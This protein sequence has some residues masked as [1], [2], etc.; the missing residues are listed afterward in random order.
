LPDVSIAVTGLARHGSLRS[1]GYSLREECE[2]RD[3][4]MSSK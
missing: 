3:E 4:S 2:R 1:R